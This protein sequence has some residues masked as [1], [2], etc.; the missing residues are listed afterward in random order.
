MSD[1]T[2]QTMDELRAEFARLKRSKKLHP[3]AE[4]RLA[5][6][7]QGIYPEAYAKPEPGEMPGGR[8]D[9]AFYFGSGRYAVFEVFATVSQVAQ[10]LRHLE[11]SN[12]QARI[13]IL[14]DPTL[15]DGKIF[16]EYFSK[17]PRD[18][19]PHMKLS[20][21]LVLEN[22]DAAKMKL[23]QYIDSAFELNSIASEATTDIAA[24]LA[25]LSLADESDED[26]GKN[27]FTANVVALNSRYVIFTAIPLRKAACSATHVLKTT[28]TMLQPENWYSSQPGV[29]LPP[30]YWPPRIFEVPNSTRSAGNALAWEDMAYGTH[31][32]RSRLVTTGSAEVIFVSA[33][34]FVYPLK[35]KTGDEIPIFRIG[36]ILA[37]C[38]KLCGLVAQLYHEI[39]YAG[40]TCL[41]IAMVNTVKSH[42]G[43]YAAGYGGPRSHEY[44]FDVMYGRDDRRCHSP[45]LK[46]CETA[47]LV[48]ME[49]KQ[50]PE[51]IRRF[52]EAISLAYNDDTPRC[53][54][55]ETGLIPDCYFRER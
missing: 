42:L 26:F 39:G 43:G 13:A 3:L 30:K 1:H 40:T 18:P 36:P 53:F 9:L 22:E 55:R 41:C 2:F 8:A 29:D 51:F 7:L 19:F 28:K 38:W 20:E 17:R 11:Q 5:I 23:R 27:E 4:E 14:A 46:F 34:K 47:D 45:N 10:D 24:R 16:E 35:L 48:K 44:W 52:A 37:E 21:I 50:Q 15:D 31:E 12:A 32:V 54:D 33:N 25:E 49:P 6:L